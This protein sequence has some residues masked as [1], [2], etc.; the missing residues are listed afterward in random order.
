[1]H[2]CERVHARVWVFMHEC[3]L[4]QECVFMHEC[5]CS[6]TSVCSFRSVCSCTS[7]SVHARVCAPSGV[8]V[9][10]WVRVSFHLGGRQMGICGSCSPTFDRSSCHTEGSSPDNT[11]NTHTLSVVHNPTGVCDWVLQVDVR[12]EW[13]ALVCGMWRWNVCVYVC[14]RVSG[15]VRLTFLLHWCRLQVRD[16]LHLDSQRYSLWQGRSLL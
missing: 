11:A 14:E 9:H 7:V 2:E 1:M 15:W 16:L 12:C 10:A 6:C 3:V 13:D 8:C 5:E 4:L